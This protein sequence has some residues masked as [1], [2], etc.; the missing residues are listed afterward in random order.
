MKNKI[1]K[2]LG[3]PETD[4]EDECALTLAIWYI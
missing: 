3:H 1:H 2:N 4:S